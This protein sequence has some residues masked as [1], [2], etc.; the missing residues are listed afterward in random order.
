MLQSKEVQRGPVT[1]QIR[2][3]TRLQTIPT[4]ITS[5][6]GNRSN[7]PRNPGLC[8]GKTHIDLV[9]YTWQRQFA[10]ARGANPLVGSK[11]WPVTLTRGGDKSAE[12]GRVPKG[13][14]LDQKKSGVRR[15]ASYFS[16]VVGLAPRRRPLGGQGRW[17]LPETF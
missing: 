3:A 2:P 1:S 6:P 14:C 12:L 10:A 16:L 17:H 4:L 9:N 7:V 5:L 15:R 8:A 11:G 13:R